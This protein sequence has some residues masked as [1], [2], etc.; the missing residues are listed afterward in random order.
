MN[1][2]QRID[3]KLVVLA[4]KHLHELLPAYVSDNSTWLAGGEL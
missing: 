4:Y 3:F 1:A 2:P